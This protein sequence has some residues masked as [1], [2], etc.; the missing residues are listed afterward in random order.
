MK[1]KL[2]CIFETESESLRRSSLVEILCIGLDKI[3]KMKKKIVGIN[4]GCA[5]KKRRA[6]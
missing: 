4:V 5:I 2:C 6:V 3:K 1:E